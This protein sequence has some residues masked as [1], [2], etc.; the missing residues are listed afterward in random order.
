MFRYWTLSNL[1]L[2]LLAAPMLWLLVQSSLAHL[3]YSGYRSPG[4]DHQDEHVKTS[5][6]TAENPPEDI[7]LRM[8]LP[9]LALAITAATSFHVQII[10]RL[11]SGYPIWYMS[12]ANWI[13]SESVSGSKEK[14]TSKLVQFVVRGMIMYAIIQGA[15][16]ASF[17]PPA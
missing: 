13:E 4:I 10:S 3:R 15:L 16:F 9:Q 11:S 5:G 1:P 12:V 6:S 14:T 7:V 2:F 17:L 8:V